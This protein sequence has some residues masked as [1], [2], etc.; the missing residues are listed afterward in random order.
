MLTSTRHTAP[1]LQSPPVMRL[2]VVAFLALALLAGCGLGVEDDA[3]PPAATGA[4]SQA[5]EELSP[6]AP[7]VETLANPRPSTSSDAGTALGLPQDPIPVFQGQPLPVPVPVSP[8]SPGAA[9][10]VPLPTH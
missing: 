2:L 5:L 4:A 6:A 9:P 10:V 1:A 7:A 8:F 3:P